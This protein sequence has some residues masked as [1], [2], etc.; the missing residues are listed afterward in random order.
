M[1]L[2]LANLPDE[3]D[4]VRAWLD[5][6]LVSP[7]LPQLAGELAA[8]HGVEDTD[9]R[10]AADVLGVEHAQL[11]AEGARSLSDSALKEL[12]TQPRVLLDL[13]ADVLAAGGPY[14]QSVTTDEATEA[15]LREGRQQLKGWIE[16]AAAPAATLTLPQRSANRTPHFAGLMALAAAMLVAGWLGRM[17]ADPAP[18]PTVAST[19]WGWSA[20]D[21][22]DP[23]LDRSAYLTKL[24]DGA[25]KWSAKRPETPAALAKRIT[26]FRAGCSRLILAEHKPLPADDAAWLREKCLAWAEKIDGHLLALEKGEAPLTVREAMDETVEKLTAALRARATA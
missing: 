7:S 13:Q 20:A 1:N 18:A 5:R 11:L 8:C 24:A 23:D 21:A 15:S 25:T 6:Q 14:W 10:R 26:E 4:Q 22:L 3:P 9:A 17:T 19:G 12:L 2:L 16:A